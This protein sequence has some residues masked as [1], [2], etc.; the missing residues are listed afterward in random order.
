MSSFDLKKIKVTIENLYLEKQKLEKGDKI[1]K[2][3]G[4]GKLKIK[5]E[6]ENVSICN[7]LINVLVI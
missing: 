6:N 1:K 7:L 4:K 2:S 3:K 5:V